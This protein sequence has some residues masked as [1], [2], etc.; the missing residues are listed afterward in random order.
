MDVNVSNPRNGLATALIAI[1]VRPYRVVAFPWV[2]SLRVAPRYRD[3]GER[4]LTGMPTT[5]VQGE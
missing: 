5:R 1:I 4:P 3:V 2:P